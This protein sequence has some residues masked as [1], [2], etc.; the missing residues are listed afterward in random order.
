MEILE[1]VHPGEVTVTDFSTP[2]DNGDGLWTVS[3]Q[4]ILFRPSNFLDPVWDCL[5]CCI[6]PGPR[7]NTANFWVF[8]ALE[9]GCSIVEHSSTA[10]TYGTPSILAGN[11]VGHLDTTIF[12]RLCNMCHKTLKY[13][14]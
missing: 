14:A 4:S 9:L 8:S 7:K 13:F 6:I 3:V 5:P 2:Y 10:L 12:A 11:E 1:E